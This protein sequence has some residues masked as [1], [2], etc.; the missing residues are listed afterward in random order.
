MLLMSLLRLSGIVILLVFLMITIVVGVNRGALVGILP[1][2]VGLLGLW[3]AIAGDKGMARRRAEKE[4]ALRHEAEAFRDASLTTGLRWLRWLGMTVLLGGLTYFTVMIGLAATWR[5]GAHGAFVLML[6]LSLVLAVG[7]A[8]LLI[9]GWQVMQAGYLLHL[10]FS[11]FAHSALPVIPWRDVRGIDLKEETYRGGKNWYLVLAV[12]KAAWERLRPAVWERFVRWMAPRVDAQH[13]ILTLHC[14]WASVPA[15]TL[16]EASKK[17]ADSAGAPRIKSWHQFEPIEAAMAREALATEAKQAD[18]RVTQL[19]LKMQRLAKSSAVSADEVQALDAQVQQA[20][21]E[22]SRARETQFSQ[23]QTSLET[24]LKKFRQ[25]LRGLYLG[26][27]F[28]VVA[29][30]VKIAYA[31]M[32]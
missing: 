20:M 12:D 3:M 27:G 28:V 5:D 6:G 4:R 23:Y 14:N 31:W 16:L 7:L 30:V 32:K 2:V 17:I 25:S 15:A 24:S 26:V 21:N 29:I 19:L 1:G 11:G 8:G 10:D 13:P 22:A 18:E 9:Q